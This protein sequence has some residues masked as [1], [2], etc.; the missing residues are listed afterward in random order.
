V[1]TNGLATHLK[2]KL[3][4]YLLNEGPEF[5]KTAKENFLCI[6]PMDFWSAQ[7]KLDLKIRKIVEQNLLETVNFFISTRFTCPYQ[8]SF[9]QFFVINKKINLMMINQ[10]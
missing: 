3:N 8:Y 7:L 5:I 6:V 4:S 10:F 9:S 2:G 1:N